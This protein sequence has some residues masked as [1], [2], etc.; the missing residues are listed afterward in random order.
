MLINEV[1]K[2]KND[3]VEVHAVSRIWGRWFR[4][5]CLLLFVYQCFPLVYFSLLRLADVSVFTFLVLW[6]NEQGILFLLSIL[7]FME[8]GSYEFKP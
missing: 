2:N 4:L 3:F 8:A 7:P 5:E 6:Q 1:N